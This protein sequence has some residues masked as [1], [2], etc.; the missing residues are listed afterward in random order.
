M[1]DR[2]HALA[3][4]SSREGLDL[5]GTA[6]RPRRT[7]AERSEATIAR[8]L[9]AARDALVAVGYRATTVQEICGRAGLSQG[10]LFRHFDT[11]LAVIIAT[12]DQLADRVRREFDALFGSLPLADQTER[13]R[14]RRLLRAMSVVLRSADELA[15]LELL[16]AARTDEALRA[17]LLPL[18]RANRQAIG[19]SWARILP[20]RAARDP[21]FNATVE[22]VTLIFVG[23]TIHNAG[24]PNERRITRTLLDWAEA[25]LTRDLDP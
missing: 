18:W 6:T 23:D 25:A 13:E 12:A 20:E 11:R 4:Y 24:W 2:K 17:A 22:A 19:R 7:Q 8:L 10:A 1:Y 3:F 15:W 21:D 9:G 5:T 16:M 14:V